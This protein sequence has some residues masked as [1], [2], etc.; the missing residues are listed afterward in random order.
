MFPQ[1]MDAKFYANVYKVKD[2]SLVPED[3]WMVFLVKDNA[4]A[5]IFPDY[6]TKCFELGCD[7]EQMA[8]LRRAQ[9]RINAWRAANPSLCKNPDAAGERLMDV[10]K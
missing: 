5:A 2:Y 7:A 3:Q 8:A 6:I 10:R 4:F 1:K 9:E